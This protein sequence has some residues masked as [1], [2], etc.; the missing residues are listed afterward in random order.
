MLM[1]PTEIPLWEEAAYPA[2]LL[3]RGL[4]GAILDR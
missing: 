3:I 2:S 1:G 4:T